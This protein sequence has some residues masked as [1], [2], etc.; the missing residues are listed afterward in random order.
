MK[1][2][3]RLI[4]CQNLL[5]EDQILGEIP[6]DFDIYKRTFQIAWP[7]M[8]ESILISLI[9]AV[10][11]IMVGG[12]GADAIAAVG[13]CNQP[14]FIILAVIMSLNI[15]VTV[16]ISRRKGQQDKE[17][18]NRCLRQS[19][20]LSAGASF[21]LSLAGFFF[22]KD[23]LILA[24]A[25]PEYI[26]LAIIYFQILMIGNFFN[27]ISMTINAAQRG[28]GNTKISMRTNLVANG[29]NLC[30]DYLLINGI[31]FF[32]QMGVAG[33]ATATLIGNIIAC[34]MSI[35]SILY[36]E[37]FLHI[38]RQQ[39][40]HFDRKTLSDLYRISSSAFV[41]QVF[42]RIGFFTYAK[43]VAA[44][45]MVEFATHQVCMNIMTISFSVG[46]GLSIATSSLV[47]QSL[48]ERRSDMAI[49]YSKTTRRIGMLIGMILGIFMCIFRV[50]IISLFSNDAVIIEMGAQIMFIIA[51]TMIFQITQVITFGSLRG[52]GDVKYTAF[53]SLISVTFIRPVLTLMLCFPFAWGLIGA[54][55]SLFL[56]QFIRFSLSHL[57][58]RKGEWVYI[59]V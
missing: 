20:M 47:G 46:D 14:K 9:G 37:E 26:N 50:Q 27:C 21:L 30:F 31:A 22:A 7:S 41:E 42:M 12:I 19:I 15:G 49:V 8:M 59:Q 58:F 54:W 16:I 40:W 3:K 43:T 13:I 45:G 36:K 48:G 51:F 55:I 4:S 5:H 6:K 1:F 44:L 57:R 11:L 53:I 32:P 52:A 28:C 23:I 34:I 25:L 29:L 33:A 24:G 56:D 2:L 35:R 39:D 18:A 38:K 17:S 10:D